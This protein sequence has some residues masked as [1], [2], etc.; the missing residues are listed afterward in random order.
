[1]TMRRELSM[2]DNLGIVWVKMYLIN[3]QKR[4]PINMASIVV[5]SAVNHILEWKE[6]RS[7][8]KV[9]IC[10]LYGSIHHQMHN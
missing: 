7:Q 1:M 4:C 10:Q 8:G 2:Y 3:F 5:C 6:L 9:R